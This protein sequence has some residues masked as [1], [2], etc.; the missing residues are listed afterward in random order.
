VTDRS[1][2]TLSL[3]FAAGKLGP[4][5][6]RLVGV[7]GQERLSRLFAFDL[8]LMRDAGPFT[9][10]E[11]DALF[12]VPC[13]IALGKG[14]GD[15]VRGVIESVRRV[16][17]PGDAAFYLARMVPTVAL[18]GL[19]RTNRIFQ[20]L[21]VP[22]IVSSVLAAY[23]LQPERDFRILSRDR[24]IKREYVV[25]YEE[26]DWDFVQR[27]LEHEGRCYW[28]EHGGATELLVVADAND[29][30]TEIAA[31]ST[32]RYRSANTLTSGE[33]STVWDWEASQRRIPAR[34]AV[35]DYN[36]RTPHVRLVAKHAADE[37]TG[38]GTVMRY[39]DHWKTPEEGALV[40]RVRAERLAC[41]RRVHAGTTDCA[42]F[43]VG[44]W[45]QIEG[46]DEGER[47][48][49]YLITEIDH[50][51]GVMPG[52][53]ADPA[54]SRYAASF[55]AIALG[56]QFRP[57]QATPWPSIHGIMHGHVAADGSGRFAEIDELGRYKVSFPFDSGNAKGAAVSRWIRMAQPY[58]G[59]GYGS[60]HPLH[61]GVEVLVAFVDGD[62]DRPI[63]V[64]SVPNPHTVTPTTSQNAT[65][66]VTRTA[67]GMQI[68]LED[69][70]T[71][72]T[73]AMARKR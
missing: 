37:K 63:I 66:S 39:G 6:V 70:A 13:A 8:H 38:F 72:G 25:Q 48:G 56:V 47:D 33:E 10:D 57:E 54:A 73:T 7:R 16:A 24:S 18:L 27:W 9:D 58:S 40:A 43:R 49:K 45:F 23:R 52:D 3:S 15:V 62:P 28:F 2:Q 21:T 42:R 26:S 30:A 11:I 44:H 53:A 32:V 69:L 64:G 61:K 19:A 17:T 50:R 67:S 20:D 29:H 60:H 51:A 5:D 68:E 34:V 35:F 4:G 65:Q 1:L 46:H 59:P 22:E 12:S 71:A 36:Y 55:R 14:P 31:P 41:E